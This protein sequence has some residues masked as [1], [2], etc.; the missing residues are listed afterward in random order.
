MKDFERN[1]IFE[2][3]YAAVSIIT[4]TIIAHDLHGWLINMS[5]NLSAG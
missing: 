1:L 4:E 5:I 2:E 3:E